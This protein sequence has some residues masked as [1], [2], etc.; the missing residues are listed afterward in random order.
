MEKRQLAYLG[1]PSEVGACLKGAGLAP[2]ALRDDGFL[3]DLEKA[4][5]SIEDKGDIEGPLFFKKEQNTD[6]HFLQENIVWSKLILK[7]LR[8]CYKEDKVPLLIGGDH[9][10]SMGSIAAAKEEAN[11]NGRPLHILWFD[12]HGDFNIPETSPTGHIHGMPLAVVCGKGRKELL[13]TLSFNNSPVLGKN[14]ML[15]GA[16]DIDEG[17]SILLKNSDIQ[18]I[19]MEKI[20][21]K[22]LIF[23]VDAALK[24]AQ[25]D[26]A[27]LHVSF[28]VDVLDSRELPATGTPVEEGI[29]IKEMA[30]AFKVI[31][32]SKKMDSLD[33]VELNPLLDHKNEAVKK[34]KKLV[35]MLFI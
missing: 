28:D 14:I 29:S 34:I 4:G 22:G 25:A 31:K 18:Q 11:K 12:A 1:A 9:A 26:G 16:R 32:D 17:E 13:E 33:V 20:K 23:Y 15:V 10:V 7:A 2:Q 24:K 5:V 21:K 8:K 30:Q 35:E 3:E 6:L 19:S 27:H